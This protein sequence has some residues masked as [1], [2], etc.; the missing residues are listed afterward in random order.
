MADKHLDCKKLNC[1]MPIVR[2]SKSIREMSQGQT[3]S[4][5]ATDLAFKP[6]LQ[7]WTRQMGHEIT[8]FTDGPVQR[9]VVRKCS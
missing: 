8:E 4:I 6:D 9:A 7:A 1:P 2:I 5:E 3:L